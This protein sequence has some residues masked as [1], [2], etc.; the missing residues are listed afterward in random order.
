MIGLLSQ[1]T[2]QD[3]ASYVVPRSFFHHS[4]KPRTYLRRLYGLSASQQKR[5]GKKG[6]AKDL[7]KPPSRIQGL[8]GDRVVAAIAEKVASLDSEDSMMQQCKDFV[9]L[10][11]VDNEIKVAAE[12]EDDLERPETPSGDEER[13]TPMSAWIKDTE[14]EG[15]IVHCWDTDEEERETFA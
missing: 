3:Y 5:E 8:T 2:L 12:G 1:S 15:L 13:D 14:E 7:S 4:G 6:A 11:S 9:E 10:L